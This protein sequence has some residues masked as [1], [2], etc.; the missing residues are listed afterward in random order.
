MNK[1]DYYNLSLA[2]LNEIKRDLNNVIQDKIRYL[3]EKE[4][5][6]REQVIKHIKNN[7]ST[8]KLFLIRGLDCITRLNNCK[9]DMCQ[10]LNLLN[11][12]KE[13]DLNEYEVSLK[14]TK[15]PLTKLLYSRAHKKD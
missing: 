3:T 7:P 9:C 10:V 6:E 5:K 1:V 14:V 13:I 8:A 11:D 12:N 15:K 2:Q 4:Y